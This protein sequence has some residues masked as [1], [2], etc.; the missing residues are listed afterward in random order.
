MQELTLLHDSCRLLEAAPT[1]K[2]MTLVA[3]MINVAVTGF[4]VDTI[5]DG[6][7]RHAWQEPQLAALQEQLKGINLT[8]FVK[9]AFEEENAAEP[10]LLKAIQCIKTSICLACIQ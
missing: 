9:A 2:P 3:A 4:F 10:M 7:R 8:P 6:L 1:G 5:A